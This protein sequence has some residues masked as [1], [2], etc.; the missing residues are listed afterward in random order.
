MCPS[1]EVAANCVGTLVRFFEGFQVLSGLS[2]IFAR[3]TV[4]NALV[5]WPA[6]LEG[7]DALDPLDVLKLMAAEQLS[8]LESAQIAL[9]SAASTFVFSSFVLLI[10][11]F[12]QGK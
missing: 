6:L 8:P 10:F 3:K 5:S 1:Y 12:F 2:R 4:L 7:S 11:N 9:P